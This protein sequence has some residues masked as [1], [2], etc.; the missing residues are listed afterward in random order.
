MMRELLEGLIAVSGGPG[1]EA[2]IAAA[3][4]A[5]VQTIADE[6]Y[7][8]VLGNLYA[9][10][11]G[12]HDTETQAGDEA[13]K[14]VMLVAPMDEPALLVTDI[15]AQGF[16]RVEPLGQLDARALIGA[17]VRVGRTGRLGVVGVSETVKLDDIEFAHLFV[18]MGVADADAAHQ[19]VRVGDTATFA[20]HLEAQGEEVL[21]GHALAARAPCAVLI[22]TMM[23]VQTRATVIAVFTAQSQ[24][25]S[26]G[27]RVAAY[28]IAPDLAV[29][30]N[31]SPASD[32]PDSL[33][34]SLR[35][36]GG[37]A[38][39]ALD[40][41][42]VVAPALRDGLVGAAR[43]A[44]VDTQMEVSPRARSE[45][46]AVFLTKAG[47]PTCGLALPMRYARTLS[48]MVDLRDLDGAV[49]VLTA[50]LRD[51]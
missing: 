34:G 35:L 43:A 40:G 46:G 33:P 25:G 26:R 3:I 4:R 41:G 2:S 51:L 45:A 16:L 50:Y 30:V 21:I 36:G 44:G 22:R 39:K 19:H 28:R 18:D 31:A 5:Q 15:G 6:V 24:V 7:T 27:A 37:V 42:M 48:Q 38:V 1:Q 23:Q 17:R 14:T 32:T 12:G 11:H 10:L 29:A 9:V 8:D 20:Y 13:V 47:V 49:A